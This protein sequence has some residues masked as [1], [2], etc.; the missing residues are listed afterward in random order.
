MFGKSSMTALERAVRAVNRENFLP[1]EQLGCARDDRPL[2]IG[3]GQT[4]SQPSLVQEMTRELV[5]TTR[6][7]VLEIGTGSGYQTA[8]LAELAAQVY[9]IERIL[10]LAEV[11]QERLTRLGY[12]NIE[13]RVGDGAEGWPEAAPFDAI[14]VTAAPTAIPPALVEQL[15]RGGRMV[16]PVGPTA[17]DQTLFLVTKDAAG[18]VWQRELFGVRFV[19][20]VSDP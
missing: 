6:S 2:P 8:I 9:T 12:E 1:A 19:P 3:H 11:A 14:I 20:L 7:R 16:I 18:A 17:Q 4:I 5:L 10:D 15:G 13:F